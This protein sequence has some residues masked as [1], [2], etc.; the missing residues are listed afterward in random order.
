MLLTWLSR[1][2]DYTVRRLGT[3]VLPL[4]K[5]EWVPLKIGPLLF[6]DRNGEQRCWELCSCQGRSRRRREPKASLYKGIAP[7]DECH[8]RSVGRPLPLPQP[9]AVG[10]N[11]LPRRG[12]FTH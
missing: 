10:P 12:K 5:N 6:I 11:R 2:S 9:L 7:S 8:Q 3:A 1:F 4:L